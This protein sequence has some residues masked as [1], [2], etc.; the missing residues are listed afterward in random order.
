M[1]MRDWYYI[2]AGEKFGPIKTPELILLARTKKL[3]GDDLVWCEGLSNWTAASKIKEILA[4]TPPPIPPPR[5]QQA[6]LSEH[7]LAHGKE[8]NANGAA[9]A[10]T[11]EETSETFVEWHKR[12]LSIVHAL[13]SIICWA[14]V[15]LIWS[16]GCGFVWIPIWYLLDTADG[17]DIGSKIKSLANK[18]PV[19]QCPSCKQN[20]ARE[21]AGK[22]LL[23]NRQEHRTV[24]RYDKHYNERRISK[25][26]SI[27][28]GDK[29]G[30]T[31]RVEQ[32][33]VTIYSYSLT[34][35]CKKCGH[36]WNEHAE[37]ER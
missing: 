22:E 7:P 8:I 26:G 13:P 36:T 28:G 6:A 14:S 16:Y 27:V 33:V 17:S 4:A 20:W 30:E 32:I 11:E 12:R 35:H 25:S 19:G 24:T 3:A 29:V 21:V 23:G 1:K 31:Q 10:S 9:I 2:H 34:C 37:E 15:F 5:T 18:I